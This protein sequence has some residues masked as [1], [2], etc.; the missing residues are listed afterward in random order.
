MC[1]TFSKPFCFCLLAGL[2]LLALGASVQA[3]DLASG[4]GSAASVEGGLS[5]GGGSRYVLKEGRKKETMLIS[6]DSNIPMLV[7][8]TIDWGDGRASEDVPLAVSRPMLVLEPHESKAVEIYFQGSGLPRDRESF[9]LLSATGVP[10]IAEPHHNSMAVALRHRF[11]LFYRPAFASEHVE[12]VPE[13]LGWELRKASGA[14]GAAVV[15]S[16]PTPFY[17]TMTEVQALDA[18]GGAVRGALEPYHGGPAG[19][20]RAGRAELPRGLGVDVPVHRRFGI[21]AALPRAVAGRPEIRRPGRRELNGWTR[22][23]RVR[24][25]RARRNQVRRNQVRPGRAGCYTWTRPTAGRCFPAPSAALPAAS[26]AIRVRI[27]ALIVRGFARGPL[28]RQRLGRAPCGRLSPIHPG[29]ASTG[30]AIRGGAAVSGQ[31]R[32]GGRGRRHA[33][34]IRK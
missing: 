16:N 11:K 8:T 25:G 5:F 34:T 3:S 33:H 27:N 29:I 9:F 4:P 2:A 6:N 14:A 12:D 19:R 26:R 31:P 23:G 13:K 30:L 7:Q 22:R 32:A 1:R 21:A 10:R 17:T 24:P 18:Q 20:G 15:V 28:A